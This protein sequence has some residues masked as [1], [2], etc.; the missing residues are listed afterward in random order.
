MGSEHPS[1]PGLLSDLEL[2]GREPH[3]RNSID[4]VRALFQ[5]TLA[6]YLL[7]VILLVAAIGVTSIV[8]TQAARWTARAASWLRLDLA[9]PA[10]PATQSQ[11]L[12]IGLRPIAGRKPSRRSRVSR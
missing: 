1:L 12:A 4:P 5:I 11:R 6:V 7:P 8:V 2:H 10:K 9:R 3:D